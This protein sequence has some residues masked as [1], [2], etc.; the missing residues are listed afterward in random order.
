MVFIHQSK[1]NETNDH[2]QIA[3][4]DKVA[5]GDYIP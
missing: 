2:D 5:I 3:A 4:D 1:K